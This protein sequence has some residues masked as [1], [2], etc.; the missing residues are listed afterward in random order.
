MVRFPG[1]G[2]RGT[3]THKSNF[4]SRHFVT[5]PVSVGFRMMFLPDFSTEATGEEIQK[6]NSL[7][8]VLL[9]I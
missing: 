8:R 1:S 4:K 6:H 9:T 7:I 3:T 2:E 5:K